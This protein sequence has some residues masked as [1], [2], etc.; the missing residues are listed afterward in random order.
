M[1][2]RNRTK[3]AVS[4]FWEHELPEMEG[5]ASAVYAGNGLS[6]HM[7]ACPTPEVSDRELKVR[8]LAVAQHVFDCPLCAPVRLA[9]AYPAVRTPGTGSWTPDIQVYAVIRRLA[10]VEEH[11]V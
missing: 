6:E 8:N 7:R 4:N 9:G 5:G 1:F 11:A 3:A 10:S 2:P